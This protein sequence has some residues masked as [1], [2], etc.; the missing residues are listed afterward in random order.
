MPNWCA[1]TVTLEHDDPAMIKRAEDAFAAGRFLQEF[2]PCSKE[3]YDYQFCVTEW[4]TKWDVGNSDGINDVQE[5][6]IVLYFDSAWAPPTAAY[7]KMLTM[8]FRIYA[9]YHEPGMAFAGVWDNGSDDYYEYGD[10]TSEE[11]IETLPSD[12]DYTYGIS[13]SAILYEEENE[14]EIEEDSINLDVNNTGNK[15]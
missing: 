11:I 10:M 9:D 13:D 5:N 2:V 3:E 1:N 15:W 8:G 14:E 7:A 4:G 6:S 12:L